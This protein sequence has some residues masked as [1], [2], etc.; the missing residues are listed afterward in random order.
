MKH[1][2]PYSNVVSII[3]SSGTGKS[4]MVDQLARSV[5]AIPFNIRSANDDHGISLSCSYCVNLKIFY[6]LDL[7]FP[8]PDD[9]VRTHLVSKALAAGTTAEDIEHFYLCFLASLFSKT[10]DELKR[11]RLEYQ[12]GTKSL[13]VWWR[14]HLRRPDVR[15][16]LYSSVVNEAEGFTAETVSLMS[17]APHMFAKLR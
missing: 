13:S 6:C 8:P 11:A 17:C 16:Q 2:G 5:F 7:A 3:Q 14:D 12:K 4:R 9:L 10:K 15:L 1:E